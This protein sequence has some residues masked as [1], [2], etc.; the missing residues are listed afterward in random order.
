MKI[1]ICEDEAFYA[2]K[3]RGYTEKYFYGLG[4]PAEISVF[5]DGAPLLE[6]CGNGVSLDLIFLDIQL[7][8]S[9]GMEIASRLRE[10]DRNAAVVFVTGLEHRAAEGYAVSAFDYV[11]KS[12][13]ETRLDSVLDRFMKSRGRTSIAVTLMNGDTA[14]VPF[15]DILWVESRGRG[16]AVAVRDKTLETPM[17]IGKLAALLPPESFV[18]VHKS[19]YARIDKIKRIGGSSLEMQDGR[20]LP[21]SR[22]RRKPVMSAVMSSVKGGAE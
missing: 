6:A 20:M 7:E 2:E 19:V 11:V 16:A 15:A 10:Y 18:E 17:P 13:A 3:L 21:L 4:V 22:R 5:S 1:A 14:V 12:S 9:D 8:A